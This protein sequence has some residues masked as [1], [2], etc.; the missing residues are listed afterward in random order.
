MPRVNSPDPSVTVLFTD[1]SVQRDADRTTIPD[2]LPE[3]ADLL[4]QSFIAASER[5]TMTSP[6]LAPGLALTCYA[7]GPAKSIADAVKLSD[8]DIERSDIITLHTTPDESDVKVIEALRKKYPALRIWFGAPANQLA[9]GSTDDAIKKVLAWARLSVDNGVELLE[10]NGEGNETAPGDWV[11][12]NAAERSGLAIRL[13]ELLKALRAAHPGLALGWT[14]HDMPRSFRIPW[15][16]VLQAPL[17]IHRPQHYP[18]EK[19]RLVD[20]DEL[21]TRIDRSRRQF[22]AFADAADISAEYVPRGDAWSPYLQGWGHN[23]LV[24]AW[25]LDQAPIG[26][27]WASP[28][29][30]DQGGSIALRV[31]HT[32]R[33]EVGPGPGAIGRWQAKHGLEA[34]GTIGPKS[35][36]LL[37][38]P[39]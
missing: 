26:S 2:G 21:A 1:G 7:S 33:A 32:I 27:L 20:F 15:K 37:G 18:A 35:R 17:A 30:W 11:G 29:S 9:R 3:L 10:L 25:G 38:L 36:K 34:V 31:L 16:E 14:S 23:P 13:H 6:T 19:G 8:A 28:G 12:N 39:G 24:T 22:Q 5:H 4:E